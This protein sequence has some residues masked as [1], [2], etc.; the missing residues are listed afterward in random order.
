MR[1]SLT[2]VLGYILMLIALAAFLNAIACW[3]PSRAEAIQF[4]TSPK[5]RPVLETVQQVLK[6][7]TTGISEFDFDGVHYVITDMPKDYIAY[8]SWYCRMP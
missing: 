6:A 7:Q 4:T 3:F 8:S 5:D 2:I 1:Y